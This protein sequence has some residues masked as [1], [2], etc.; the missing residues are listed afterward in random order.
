MNFFIPPVTEGFFG[1]IKKAL[2][3][4]SEEEIYGKFIEFYGPSWNDLG[5]FLLKVHQTY[6]RIPGLKKYTIPPKLPAIGDYIR[7]FKGFDSSKTV[8]L[9][10][11]TSLDNYSLLYL[12]EYVNPILYA[13]RN[14]P[15][16][17]AAVRKAEPSFDPK[18]TSDKEL[19]NIMRAI[20]YNI[21]KDALYEHYV[22]YILPANK[23]LFRRVYNTPTRQA[24]DIEIGDLAYVM[25]F[26]EE[27]NF[28][29]D[30]E[31]RTLKQLMDRPV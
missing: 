5:K 27:T 15:E 28:I 11:R 26:N 29:I 4:Y 12:G 9:P 24:A 8:S 16:V 19:E 21:W 25:F 31:H 18:R 14:L 2:G 13:V 7:S 22:K 23:K 17:T 30:V 3:V 6:D 1:N 10:L 20:D